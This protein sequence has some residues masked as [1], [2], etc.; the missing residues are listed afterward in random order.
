M[1]ISEPEAV[2]TGSELAWKKPGVSLLTIA[3]LAERRPGRY[4]FRF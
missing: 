2:A 1:P 3:F 4:R